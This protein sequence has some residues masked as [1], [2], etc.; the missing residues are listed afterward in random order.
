[1]AK[2]AKQAIP[3][4][5]FLLIGFLLFPSAGRDDVHISYWA[6]HSL[7]NFGEI[8]NYNGA[9][10]EQSSSLLHTVLLAGFGYLTQANLVTIG[11]L[12]S[13][14]CGLGTVFLTG[15]LARLLK[16]DGYFPQ[17]FVA[18]SVP[19]VYWSFGGLETS[20]TSLVVVLL[21]IQ[22][23]VYFKHP[24]KPNY[25]I[26]LAI[27]LAY[28]TVR[29]ES[30]FIL[31]VCLILAG[32]VFF[33][34]KINLRPFVY[35]TLGTLALFAGILLF[36]YFYFEAF[37]PLPVRAKIGADHLNNVI[38]GILYY[39]KAA[40]QYP[41]FV[42]L[43]IFISIPFFKSFKKLL[44][45]LPLALITSF[46][47]AHVLFV[48]T[49]GGDWMEG[50][51][52]LAPILSPLFILV[53]AFHP[54]MN[55]RPG[56]IYSGLG[57]NLIAL[58]Y[59]VHFFSTSSPI[60]HYEQFS[61]KVNQTDRFSFFEIANRVHYRDIFLTNAC[62]DLVDTLTSKGIHPTIMSGQAG[63]ISYHLNK[64]C[65]GQITFFDRFALT[66]PDLLSCEQTR[67]L[68]KKV[69]GIQFDYPYFFQKFNTLHETCGFEYPDII[70]DLGHHRRKRELLIESKGYSIVFHQKGRINPKGLFPGFPV[71]GNQF[72]AVKDSLF[73]QFN[74]KKTTYTFK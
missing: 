7:S 42:L 65:H 1:M 70:F 18:T 60:W 20:L 31:I 62:I 67:N 29:P 44:E 52:F 10:V 37:F 38:Q 21:L 41:P 35:L 64:K 4:L 24:S 13:I 40:I 17:L 5:L 8:L 45:N 50:A 74:L 48:V 11:S 57:L 28:L 53:C 56:F 19:L 39:Q 26:C 3:Y 54:N 9:R 23:I 72:I 49:S 47:I 58:L 16:L 14:T 43:F 2:T 71:W 25:G 68:P 12:F 61:E 51:R 22:L 30:I 59:F 73:S 46:V 63:M 6:A 27:I 15:V 66:T 33:V 36:R 32:G 34:Q 55:Q 69:R